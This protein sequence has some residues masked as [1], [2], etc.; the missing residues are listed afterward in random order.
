MRADATRSPAPAAAPPLRRPPRIRFD[1][2]EVAGAFGDIGTDLP[3]LV[4]MILAA[5]LDSASV[6]IVFG[7]MQWFTAVRYGLPMPV[8]PLKAMAVLVIAQQ[9]PGNVLYGA[10][11][12]IGASMLLLTLTGGL[13]WLARVIPRTVIRGVQFG[14]GAQLALLALRDYV[15]ADA[16]AGYV[17][18]GVAFVL[19]VALL[20]NRRYPPALFVVLLGVVYAAVFKLEPAAV[21]ESVGFSLPNLY[22]PTWADIATGFVLLALPQIP[23]SLGNS[24]LATRQVVEDLFPERRLGVRQIGLT[25]SLMNLVGPWL[26]GVPT[27]HGSG[28]VAGHHAFGARTGGSLIVYGSLFLVLGLFFSDGFETLVQ[29]FPLPIL[30]VILLFEG[31]A[32]MLLVRDTA[33]SAADFGVVLLVGLMANGLPYGY[34]I[35]VVVGTLLVHLMRWRANGAAERGDA[36]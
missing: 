29:V 26:S 8:Q 3:L 19:T 18:A 6:L 36:G 28:G 13:D 1:R 10:G 35:G 16:L 14:L 27:C 22:R 25:Y 15:G 9:L 23:L 31:L 17:L 30:G 20:G 24:I 7:L 21:R 33:G 12:A 5:G 11:L 2:N 34:L 4:G 32:M